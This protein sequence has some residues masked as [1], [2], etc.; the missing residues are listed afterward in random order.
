MVSTPVKNISQ[1]GNLPQL[2]VKIKYI[3]HHLDYAVL[4]GRLQVLALPSNAGNP[5]K[6]RILVLL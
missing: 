6:I 5:A 1:I 2:G 3:N 4:F